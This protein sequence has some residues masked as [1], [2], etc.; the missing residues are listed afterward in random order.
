VEERPTSSR[1][2]QQWLRDVDA[3]LH[4]QGMDA[5]ARLASQAL[6]EGVE[7]PAILNLAAS[8]YF[9]DGS[10]AEAVRLLR[11]ANELAPDDPHV[12]NSLG[13]CLK[14]AGDRKASLEAFD[15]AARIDPGMTEVHFNRGTVLDD[16]NDMRGAR[17]AYEQA[18]VLEPNYSDA[19]A[20]LAWIEA[21]TGN[22]SAAR[23][24]GERVLSK[25]PAN[26]LACMAMASADL[27][28]GNLAAAAA[29]LTPLSQASNLSQVNRSIVVGMIADIYDAT[30][31]PAEAFAVY[32]ASNDLLKLL[33]PEF[34]TP[35]RETALQRVKRLANWFETA[36]PAL[37]QKALAPQ[38][39]AVEPR[40]HVFVVGFPRSGTTLLENVL[41]A[42]PNVVSLEEKPLL[43]EAEAAYL[44][45]NDGLERL[46]RIDPDDAQR[47]RNRYWELV[48]R[49]GVEPRGRVLIDKMPLASV[50]LPLIAKLF[51]D[52][53]ILF[54]IRDPRD[55]VWSCFRRRFAMN[56][57]MYELL[58][59]EGAATYYD[60]VMRLSELYR[61][62]LPLPQDIVRYE[63]LVDDFEG[64]TRSIFDF[65]DL[66][67]DQ[68]VVDFAGKARERGIDTPSAA[69]VVRGLNR[70]GQGTWRRYRDQ[71]TPVLPLLDGWVR[72]FGY[73]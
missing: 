24:D 68:G 41:A 72:A 48:R 11:R 17:S 62:L 5:A 38:A 33:H 34:E 14:A 46:S 29:R 2:R 35:G 13:V 31:R 59:L 61:E 23:S 26:V 9:S 55:V 28:D 7:D 6:A 44:S 18:L 42:H 22:A 10:F 50:Q 67:W 64:T 57:S 45:S 47:L 16:E 63:S 36:D 39:G 43:D 40:A 32:Q 73:E 3:V 25:S 66:E 69:Q 8:R 54:A 30:N 1:S 65:L 19:R 52:A 56:A 71:M 27:Q 58:T 51:P 21:Q 53:R 70:E 60:A 12:L 20:A 15:A 37:W 4:T 49:F